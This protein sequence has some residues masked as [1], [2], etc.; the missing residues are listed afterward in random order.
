LS[1]SFLSSQKALA[2]TPVAIA[3][4]GI[5]VA[6]RCRAERMSCVPCRKKPIE[7]RVGR[8]IVDCDK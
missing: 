3:V 7:L 6:V 2:A 4:V 8:Y 5:N 1:I